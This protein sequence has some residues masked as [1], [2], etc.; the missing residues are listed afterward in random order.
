MKLWKDGDKVVKKIK[1]IDGTG[2]SRS[3]E[4]VKYGRVI[5]ACGIGR[6]GR[7]RGCGGWRKFNRR[8]N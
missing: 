4:T 7:V 5:G 6:F 3:L 1:E 8:N 2:W